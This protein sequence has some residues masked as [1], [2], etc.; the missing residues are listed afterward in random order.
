MATDLLRKLGLRI[1]EVRTEHGL[2]QGELAERVGFRSSYISQVENGGKGTTLDTL[3]AI[4]AVL[5]MTLSELML[6]IDHPVPDG[7]E[8]L[9]IA[10][11]GQSPARQQ[12]LLR[13]LADALRLAGD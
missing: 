5:G 11:A 2:T 12:I 10:L 4:A 1:R 7:F 8:R 13:I 9:S 3:A 6:G